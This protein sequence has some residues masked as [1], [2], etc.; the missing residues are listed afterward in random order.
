MSTSADRFG[1]K[2]GGEKMWGLQELNYPEPIAYWPQTWGWVVVGILVL[3]L[4]AW[5]VYRRWL[6]WKKNE[7]RRQAMHCLEQIA[8]G[9]LSIHALPKLL[10]ATALQGYP[11][12]QIVQ[13]NGKD[14]VDWLNQSANASLYE[15]TD[16]AIF[17]SLAYCKVDSLNLS[18]QESQR[19]VSVSRQW[20][21][22]HH[23][24]L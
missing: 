18:K 22:V 20:V 5:L 13:L 4:I 1:D 14:W 8:N 10:R 17:D 23:A 7:Y 15:Q 16:A 2:F 6:V 9:S 24:A 19:L 21:K 3:I 12:K 11:R